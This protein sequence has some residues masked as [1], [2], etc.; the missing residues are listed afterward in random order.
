MWNMGHK[1]FIFKPD[2]GFM[3][4]NIGSKNKDAASKFSRHSMLIEGQRDASYSII[5]LTIEVS[6]NTAE[7]LCNPP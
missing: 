3:K 4:D 7:G 6:K 2:L 1:T 5:S